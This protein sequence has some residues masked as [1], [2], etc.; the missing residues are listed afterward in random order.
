MRFDLILRWA[1]ALS[2]IT[3]CLEA[4]AEVTYLSCSGTLR[5]IRAGVSSLV[6][7]WTFALTID[8]ERKTI[9]VDDYEA[10]P[11]FDT[12]RD[13]IGFWPSRRTDFGV[14]TGTLHRV[15]GET[16]I[17][18]IKDGLQI[19]T[20]ICKPAPETVTNVWRRRGRLPVQP[21]S[22]RRWRRAPR[23]FR[24]QGSRYRRGK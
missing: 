14:S 4:R 22:T 17:Q 10:V 5:M 2:F 6:D 20:G 13:T 9:A 24:R 18:I 1:V 23:C 11:F 12:S 7:P 8:M 21:D 3:P 15:T 16:R 19:L